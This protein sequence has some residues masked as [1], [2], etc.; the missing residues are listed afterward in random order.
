MNSSFLALGWA[1]I[2]FCWEASLLVAVYYGADCIFRKASSHSRYLLTLLTLFSM[3]LVALLTVTYETIRYSITPALDRGNSLSSVVVGSSL[4]PLVINLAPLT[5]GP[6]HFQLAALFPWLDLTWLA[7]VLVLSVRSFGGWWFLQRLRKSALAEVPIAVRTAFSKVSA[8]LGIT[9][10]IDVRI[11]E[12][13]S[14]PMTIG[15]L[16]ALVLLPVSTLLA[17]SP[18]QLEVVLAHELAHVRRADYFWNL[19]QTMVETLLFFH[20]AVWWIGKRLR[21]QRELCCDDIAVETCCDP[22]VYATALLRMEEERR[23]NVTLAMALDGH[24]PVSGSRARIFRILREPL[25]KPNRF[26]LRPLSLL[27][28]VIGFLLFLA[29]LPALFG[30]IVASIVQ[31]NAYLNKLSINVVR[32]NESFASEISDLIPLQPQL[33]TVRIGQPP[34][35]AAQTRTQAQRQEGDNASKEI[36]QYIDEMRASGY[37]VP[38]NKYVS[39]KAV[40]ITPGYAQEM[41]TL[42]FGKPSANDLLALKTQRITGKYVR[43]LHA[44]GF[45][46][47]SVRQVI[48]YRLLRITPEF[49]SEMRAVGFDSIPPRQVVELRAEH[50]TSEYANDVKRQIPSVTT[51]QLIR[52]RALHIDQSFIA[53][54]NS[55]G[56]SPLTVQTLLKLR[57][58]G[59]LNGTH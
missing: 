44:E 51:E 33:T 53:E 23:H 34:I 9:R 7:G 12:V 32:E 59:V 24:Q 14:G 43:E 5:R 19:I 22:L 10:S 48:S 29:P 36:G 38:P 52:L 18:E 17:L 13:I 39:M 54:A 6:V 45:N 47:D 27:V 37:V 58:S 28:V 25:P 11:C 46:T 35:Y 8:K 55:R 1:L 42:G 2:H 26:G 56:F 57:A 21:A 50:I 31:R 16:R 49:I 40:G 3:L 20:P 30:S 15:I 4:N 41:G